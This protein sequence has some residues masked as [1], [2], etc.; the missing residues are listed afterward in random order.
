[1]L[2][3]SNRMTKSVPDLVDSIMKAPSLVK[4]EL[5]RKTL[6]MNQFRPTITKIRVST[7]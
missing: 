3:T 4:E 1:M 7:F 6:K 5:R 2:R